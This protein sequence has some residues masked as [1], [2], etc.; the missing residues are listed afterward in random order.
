[1]FLIELENAVNSQF[2]VRFL[3]KNREILA[4]ESSETLNT[5]GFKKGDLITVIVTPLDGESEGNSMKSRPVIIANSPPEITSIPQADIVDGQYRYEVTAEDPDDDT[6]TFSLQDS[7]DGMVIDSKTGAIEWNVSEVPP[8]AY[9]IKVI[10][11]DGDAKAFQS[12]ILN[13]TAR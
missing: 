10:V 12:F 5:S 4:G 2:L 1:M 7:P 11:G 8:G 9:N 3:M 6:L 13:L